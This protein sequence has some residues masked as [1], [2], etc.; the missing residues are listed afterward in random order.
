MVLEGHCR[1]GKSRGLNLRYFREGSLSLARFKWSIRAERQGGGFSS[2]IGII[3]DQ[4]W[5]A[6]F[7]KRSP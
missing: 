1:L 4:N 5:A 3:A 7:K 2:Y 6:L